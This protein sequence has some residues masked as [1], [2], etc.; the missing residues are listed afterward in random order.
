MYPNDTAVEIITVPPATENV[1]LLVDLAVWDAPWSTFQTRTYL[2]KHREQELWDELFGPESGV[3]SPKVSWNFL[4][5]VAFLFVLHA[6]DFSY[7]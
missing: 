3:K 6:F 1:C 4:I 5:L 2:N 7:N